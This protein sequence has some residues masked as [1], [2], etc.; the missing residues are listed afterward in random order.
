MQC[1]RIAAICDL[2]LYVCTYVCMYVCVVQERAEVI[3]SMPPLCWVFADS[4]G[5]LHEWWF[6]LQLDRHV[7]GNVTFF[8]HLLHN[9][10][11]N[12][13]ILHMSRVAPLFTTSAWCNPILGMLRFNDAVEAH[14][15][16]GNVRNVT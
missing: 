14:G 5:T 8:C 6:R 3:F 1:V 13:Q 9:L 4:N 15:C 7:S 2:L 16:V 11:Q 10:V 12:V